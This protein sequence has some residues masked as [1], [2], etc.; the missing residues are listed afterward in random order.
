MHY[1]GGALVERYW[2]GKTLR[3]LRK[4]IFTAISFTIKPHMTQLG[5][6]LGTSRLDL[7]TDRLI[8]G[9]L[10]KCFSFLFLP[11]ST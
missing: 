8:H 11:L 3:T 4:P 5:F 1:E 10:P 9:S 2:Q 6:E 7:A